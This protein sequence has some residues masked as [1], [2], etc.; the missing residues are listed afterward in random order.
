MVATDP[1]SCDPLRLRS[2]DNWSCDEWGVVLSSYWLEEAVLT[3]E[4]GRDTPTVCSTR[5]EEVQI[6]HYATNY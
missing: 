2:C 5:E 4:A 3:D 1:V 6:L